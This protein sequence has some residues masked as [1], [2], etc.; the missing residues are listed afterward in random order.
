MTVPQTDVQNDR[1]PAHWRFQYANGSKIQRNMQTFAQQTQ[2]NEQNM[3]GLHPL[4][5]RTRPITLIITGRR[6]AGDAALNAA[7]MNKR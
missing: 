1:V 2:T 7:E 3:S 4:V 5:L 6:A